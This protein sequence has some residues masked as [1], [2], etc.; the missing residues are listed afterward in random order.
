MVIVDE[1][2]ELDSGA[3]ATDSELN[4]ETLH[5]QLAISRDKLSL[6]FSLDR[7][8]GES[9]LMRRVQD[10]VRLA[11][12]QPTHVVV[13]GTAGSGREHAGLPSEIHNSF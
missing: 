5:Q 3:S 12:E 7:L 6:P 10:Q 13:T 9:P 4:A 2:S 11:I 8:V 1:W